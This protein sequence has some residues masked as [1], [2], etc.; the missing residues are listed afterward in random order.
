MRMGFVTKTHYSAKSR[1]SHHHRKRAINNIKDIELICKD[2]RRKAGQEV[3]ISA[4]NVIP[5]YA[6]HDIHPGVRCDQSN[7][8]EFKMCVSPRVY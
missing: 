3:K 2:A 5:L 4:L 8:P 6:V 1:L 7:E